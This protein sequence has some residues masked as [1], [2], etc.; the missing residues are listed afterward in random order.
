MVVKCKLAAAAVAGTSHRARGQPCQDYT[1]KVHDRVISAIALADGAGTAVHSAS[2]AVITVTSILKLLRNEFNR[3]LEIAGDPCAERIIHTLQH[4]LDCYARRKG[5][6]RRDLAATLLFVA[7]DGVHYLCGQLGDGRIAR[8]N[9]DCSAAV[10]VFAPAKG[11]YFNQTAFVTDRGAL[12]DFTLDWGERAD[13]GGFALMSD[14]TEE[15]LYQRR[16]ATFAPALLKMLGWLDQYSETTVHQALTRNLTD[17]LSCRTGDDLS[18][19]LMRFASV[20][21]R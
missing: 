11:E 18:I 15:S 13:V 8:C 6:V 12:D 3:L 17:I 16:T 10:S 5:V 14:G 2:G 7:T 9:A 20:P 21:C 4:S 1:A 19:A